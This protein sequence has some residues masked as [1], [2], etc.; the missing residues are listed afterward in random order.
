MGHGGRQGGGAEEQGR[1]SGV[2]QGVA[3]MERLA[4]D[5]AGSRRARL[6]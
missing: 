4:V 3:R 1:G 2:R 5:R 6:R